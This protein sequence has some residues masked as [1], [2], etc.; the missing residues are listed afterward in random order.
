MSETARRTR[1]ESLTLTRSG[2][3]STLR[4]EACRTAGVRWAMRNVS[5]RFWPVDALRL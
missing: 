3:A 5:F 4:R 1:R 2:C